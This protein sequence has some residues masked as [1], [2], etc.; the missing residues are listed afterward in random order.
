MKT[1]QKTISKSIDFM[2][3]KMEDTIKIAAT[4]IILIAGCWMV[5]KLSKEMLKELEGMGL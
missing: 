4:T 3:V 1:E 2:P 5:L